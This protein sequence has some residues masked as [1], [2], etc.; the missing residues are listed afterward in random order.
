M[1]LGGFILKCACTWIADKDTVMSFQGRTKLLMLGCFAYMYTHM[2]LLNINRF[3]NARQYSVLTVTMY[4]CARTNPHVHVLLD[5]CN[6]LWGEP[7]QAA[8]SATPTA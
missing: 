8:I 6:T 2:W 5:E 4:K 1:H 3:P 7:S